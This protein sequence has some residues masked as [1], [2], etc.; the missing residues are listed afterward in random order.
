[1][2]KITKLFTN[3]KAEETWLAQQKGWKLVYTNGIRYTFEESCCIY[4]YEYIY[5]DKSKKELDDIRKQI[6]DD[7]IEFV[8]N[9]S[10]WALFRKDAA[11]GQ[12]HVYADN[13]LK[14]K[15]LMKKYKS[16][17]ALGACYMC[18]GSSQVALA[19]AVN[20]FFNLASPLF[21][22]SSFMFFMA[23]SSYKKYSLEYDDGSYAERMKKEK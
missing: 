11:K 20:S 7:D 17:M 5:F 14:Y 16:A 12:I 13:Y 23:A 18:L 8:C 15:I 1:M 19:S 3:I 9:S 4:N 6:V 22:L 21:Y 10:S 2:K